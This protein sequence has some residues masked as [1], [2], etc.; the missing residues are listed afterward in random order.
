MA[1]F[2]YCHPW[3]TSWVLHGLLVEQWGPIAA[4]A[5]YHLGWHVCE[6][7]MKCRPVVGS[8]RSVGGSRRPHRAPH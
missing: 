1:A 5:I 2:S 4:V 7:N 3:G 6:W 8:R